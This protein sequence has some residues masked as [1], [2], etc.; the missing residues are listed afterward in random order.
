MFDVI[1]AVMFLLIIVA[2]F[3]SYRDTKNKIETLNNNIRNSNAV[4]DNEKLIRKDITDSLHT[5]LT[6][7]EKRGMQNT[8][9]QRGWYVLE[10]EGSTFTSW[11]DKK[12]KHLKI[13]EFLS[14]NAQLGKT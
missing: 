14:S 2:T 5:R 3:V 11:L 8:G 6:Q 9:F 12:P 7:V 4:I 10:C 13:V 1:V